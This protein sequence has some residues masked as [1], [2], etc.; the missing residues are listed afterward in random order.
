MNKTLKTT[1]IFL[2]KLIP[3]I[4]TILIVKANFLLFKTNQQE[5]QLS[6]LWGIL[7]TAVLLVILF[8]NLKDIIKSFSHSQNT[9]SH[10]KILVILNV[11][12]IVFMISSFTEMVVT[13]YFEPLAAH[14]F[15]MFPFMYGLL[16]YIA[17]LIIDSI[18]LF[19][20]NKSLNFVTHFN[21]LFIAFFMLHGLWIITQPD[22]EIQTVK[23]RLNREATSNIDITPSKNYLGHSA[24]F[25]G[26]TDSPYGYLIYNPDEKAK[27]TD[28]KY[29][30][31]VFFHG[32]AEFGV[33]SFDNAV[34]KRL[35]IHGPPRLIK[36]GKWSTPEP[37]IVASPQQ[38]YNNN[39]FRPGKV[40]EFLKHLIDNY[41]VDEKRIYLTGLSMGGNGILH[42][43]NTY[44]DDA[45]ATAI[46]P[47]SSNGL[48]A[49]NKRY[50]LTTRQ[51]G[52]NGFETMHGVSP[53]LKPENFKNIPVWGFIN[54]AENY[55]GLSKE[56]EA[57]NAI[58]GKSK[59]TVYPKP[60]HDA[61][62][63]TYNNKGQGLERPDFAPFDQN[64]YEW[65]LQ[66]SREDI[67][68]DI[69]N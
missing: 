30:L 31:L 41:P 5:I 18:R 14:K 34:L 35:T 21:I 6:L 69:S 25:L 67:H 57:I 13:E 43:I 16:C 61:W 40:H 44:G 60:G 29:P 37:M 63:R 17:K 62:T 23:K 24:Y 42:Y 10:S 36:Q 7:T 1:L 4:G 32:G 66:Q 64:I 9:K 54:E 39:T 51:N 49:E 58:N 27:S 2:E 11:A 55:K 68:Q 12:F 47:V 3:V 50:S 26:T 53:I 22:F 33:S 52:G 19:F 38:T 65:L 46:L 28:G 59:T 48:E 56:I 20:A 15:I 45:Y 8:F